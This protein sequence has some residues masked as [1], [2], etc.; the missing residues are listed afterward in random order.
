MI[1]IISFI[2]FLILITSI[3]VLSKSKEEISII[4]VGDIMMGTDFPTRYKILPPDNGKHLFIHVENLLLKGDL[5]FGNLEQVIINAQKISILL[6]C[7][8]LNALQYLQPILQK[9][10]LIL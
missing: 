8:L 7:G 2:V 10:I 5:V 6:I 9:P 4:A 3:P 1:K